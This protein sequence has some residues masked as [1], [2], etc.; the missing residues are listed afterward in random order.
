M[1][2]SEEVIPVRSLHLQKPAS[3]NMQNKEH[4]KNVIFDKVD[5]FSIYFFNLHVCR[6]N[7]FEINLQ[8]I[9]LQPN[10]LVLLDGEKR[11]DL[12]WQYLLERCKFYV[13]VS[14][15]LYIVP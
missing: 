11:T 9:F 12:K 3:N 7:Q 15:M 2:S 8:L 6:I 13:K 4:A 10:D 14:K 5:Q 1:L